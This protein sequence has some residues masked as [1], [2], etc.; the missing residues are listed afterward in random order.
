MVEKMTIVDDDGKEKQVFSLIG[1]WGFY[2]EKEMALEIIKGLEKFY[3]VD[4][5]D[6]FID[7]ANKEM[8][9]A[10]SPDWK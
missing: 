5:V 8:R 7:G 1:D 2:L 9:L 6:D 3:K 10:A 4:G